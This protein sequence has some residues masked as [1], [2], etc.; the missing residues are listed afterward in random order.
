MLITNRKER[1]AALP[2]AICLEDSHV[3]TRFT[4]IG[5]P[6][7]IIIDPTDAIIENKMDASPK[8]R[9]ASIMKRA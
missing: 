7:Q 8:S 4:V 6:G 5:K 3:K 9:E 2:L 1:S